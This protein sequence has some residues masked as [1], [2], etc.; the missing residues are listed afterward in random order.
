MTDLGAPSPRAHKSFDPDLS[1]KTKQCTGGLSPK[2]LQFLQT[3][4]EI[5]LYTC[6]FCGKR[7]LYAV[8]NGSGNWAL[9]LHYEPP[10]RRKI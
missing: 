10:P 6:S 4:S 7:N 5:R 1:V 2:E 8:R 9:E 3:E